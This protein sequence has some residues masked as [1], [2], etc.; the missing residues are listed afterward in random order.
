[1]AVSSYRR[2]I[3]KYGGAAAS[4]LS[5]L[6]N[7]ADR[8]ESEDIRLSVVLT[9][10]PGD[11]PLDASAEA[12]RAAVRPHLLAQPE[13]PA[14]LLV[15]GDDVLPFFRL[16]NPVRDRAVDPDP[17]V[18]TDAPYSILEQDRTIP[19]GRI[20]DGRA[21]EVAQFLS[22]LEGL[23][24]RPTQGRHGLLAVFNH[25]WR[26]SAAAVVVGH[27]AQM[28]IAPKWTAT[29][30]EWR[31]ARPA[32]LYFNL[33]G[34]A[35]RGEW[36]GMNDDTGTWHDVLKPA[37]VTKDSGAGAFVFSE[38]C[39]GAAVVGKSSQTSIALA[40]VGAQCRGFV[41]ATGLA[42][43]SY[44]VSLRPG[45]ADALASHLLDDVM[46]G[47]TFG[48]SLLSARE[49]ARSETRDSPF[50]LKTSYQFVLYGN[51]LARL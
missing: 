6:R 25:E 3:D 51:P 11:P 32:C 33:H 5:E 13:R 49:R 1:V 29:S 19:V 20:P 44:T 31:S 40:F 15:G 23:G 38:A 26:T 17:H 21:E 22:A 37:D 34:F 42:F 30:P 48:A 16:S 46:G 12:I 36:R 43:G 2:L 10:Q 27:A 7:A 4:I 8:V 39:Y 47:A 14:L 50:S 28:R 41:G 18:L 9:E 24:A 45:F 35:D